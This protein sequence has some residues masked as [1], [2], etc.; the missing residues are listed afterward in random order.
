M[1]RLISIGLLT[2]ILLSSTEGIQLLKLPYIFKHFAQH[3]R[4][5]SHLSF[6]GFL[7]M[8]YL[9]GSPHDSDYE[10]DMKLPF[11]RTDN[12]QLSQSAAYALPDQHIILTI[13]Q[14]L[15]RRVYTFYHTPFIPAG[16]LSCI[17]QPPKSC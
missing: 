16:Y 9:H 3:H 6:L 5:D 11:K 2:V 10:E 1:K 13:P 12:C 14:G 17:W 15:P 7:A 8:H 4:Q